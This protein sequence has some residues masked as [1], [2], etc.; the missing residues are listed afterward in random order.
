LIPAAGE[1]FGEWT[2]LEASPIAGG[3][4]DAR[5]TDSE[6]REV[7]LWVGAAGVGADP[8]EVE[9]VRARLS[10]IYHSSLPRV[11]GAAIVGDRAAVAVQAYCGPTLA[12][13]LVSGPL[14][15]PAAIDVAR[16]VAA[17][18]VKA[19]RAEVMHGAITPEEIILAEDGRTLLAH[20]GLAPF[21]EARAPRAPEDAGPT[22]AESAD[23][24]GLSRALVQALEGTDPLD[25]EGAAPADWG[26]RAAESFDPGLPEGLRRL[27]SRALLPD[28]T[29][30]VRHAEELAGDLGVIRAS[31]D[32]MTAAPP[33]P[34]VPFPALPRPAVL[35]IGI[36]TLLAV[37]LGLRAC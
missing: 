20:L 26:G 28:P 6:G 13:R 2:V 1:G 32:T 36:L 7:R 16:G 15:A 11:L 35:A 30:R 19:H 34:T 27:L 17:G 29:R 9:A 4:F 37:L 10:R 31:W 24:F 8:A 22:G 25:R 23:V 3:G 12:E 21:L 33:R 5:A 14:D 18:L